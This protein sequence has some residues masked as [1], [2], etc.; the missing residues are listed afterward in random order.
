[1]ESVIK[2]HTGEPEEKGD[3]LV[4]LK[5]GCVKVDNFGILEKKWFV[6]NSDFILAWCKL[7][8][9]EPYKEETMKNKLEQITLDIPKGY[10]FFGINDDNQVVLSKKQ[11]QYP[12]TYE[13]CARLLDTF[14]GSIEGYNGTLLFY[15]EQLLVC[16]DA[17]WKIAGDWKP[18]WK[19]SDGGYRYCIRNQSNKIIFNNEWLGKN[20][21]LSFPI[22]EMRDAF[23]KNFKELIEECKE[24]L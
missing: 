4:A 1:M 9:I 15:F 11:L 16:R 21:I 18:D 13:E 10:E 7:S 14:C 2:W 8:E 12:N 20:Y 5:N 24:L 23:H 22:Q 6:F 17:Y 3:Y 19:K